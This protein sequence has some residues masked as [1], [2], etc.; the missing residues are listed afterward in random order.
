MEVQN[1]LSRNAPTV[2]LTTDASKLGWGAVLD[3]QSTGGLWFSTE[4]QN[5]INYLELLAVFLGLQTFCSSLHDC[6]IRLMVDNTT[7][8]AV[9]N[10]MGTS[11]SD[12]LTKLTK[13]IWLWCI[14]RNIW[15]SAAH[16]AGKCN[17]QADLES[18]HS[19]TE[20]EWM[21]NNTLSLERLERARFHP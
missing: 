2:T 8:V 3:T 17:I 16:I 15:L 21:L 18:R 7:A 10:H 13:E 14:P 11:H 12:P 6:H 5:H 20:T 1:I 4:S 19:V 9:I